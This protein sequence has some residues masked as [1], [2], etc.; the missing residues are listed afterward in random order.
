MYAGHVAC[1]SP[2]SVTVSMLKG[3]Q[4]DARPLLIHYIMLSAICSQLNIVMTATAL[5][6]AVF[7]KL[8]NEQYGND[9]H[10]SCTLQLCK[11]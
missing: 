2:W 3:R 10:A 7:Q 5:D 4:T 11:Q 8:M 9:Y 6:T 1:C